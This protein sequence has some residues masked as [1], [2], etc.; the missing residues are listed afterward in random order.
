MKKNIF[1]RL[2]SFAMALVLV[3][4]WLPYLATEVQAAPVSHTYSGVTLQAS[5]AE[6]PSCMGTPNQCYLGTT[7]GWIKITG[8]RTGTV[9]TGSWQG[10]KV[11]YIDYS[12]Y[13][14]CTTCK[15]KR[16]GSGT[17]AAR[18]EA[19]CGRSI[20]TDTVN[21]SGCMLGNGQSINTPGHVISS[22]TGN[23]TS[24]S[25]NCLIH[26]TVSA[27]CSGGT[28]N[29]TQKAVCSTCQTA[30]GSTND[31][32]SWGGWVSNGNNTHTRTCNNNSA[33]K[34]TQNCSGGTAT[35]STPATCK[36]CNQTYGPRQDHTLTYA[37]KSGTTNVLEET[38]QNNCGHIAT[39]TL[40]PDKSEYIFDPEYTVGGATLTFSDNWAGSK[41]YHLSFEDNDD[42]GTATVAATVYA[43]PRN[44]L[45]C[46]YRILPADISQ[47]FA[48]CIPDVYNGNALNAA[49]YYRAK[50][51][52]IGGHKLTEGQDY[53][54]E[55]DQTD[56]TQAGEYNITVTGI[57]NYTGSFTQK[58]TVKP[59]NLKNVSV[60]N[61]IT[62]FDYT[63]KAQK[64]D[65]TASGETVDGSQV[66]FTYRMGESGEYVS[67]PAVTNGGTHTVY[68][69]ASA[70]NHNDVTG[71]FIVT[72][73]PANGDSSVSIAGWS[74]GN[75]ASTPV[76]VSS[77]NGTENVTYQYKIKG[78]D[79]STYIDA[80]PTLPG[81]YTVK[82]SFP[83]T[84]NYKATEATADFTITKR[85]V[86]A[87]VTAQNKTYNGN[88]DAVITA[89]VEDA[90]YGDTL[91]ISGLTGAF[92]DANAGES[93]T[94]TVDS[95]N[96]SVT[97][98][99]ADC[100]VVS[101]PAEVPA[102]IAKA[103][104]PAITFPEVR[105]AITY[106]QS[107][108]EA[109]L[110]FYANDYGT[111]AW[112]A[113]TSVPNAGTAGYALDF[114]PNELALHNY[115]W[116]NA[117]G[118]QWIGSRNA[119]CTCPDVTV[120]KAP[121]TATAP[122]TV[123]SLV[124]NTAPQTLIAAG[125]TNDGT[126]V[127][128][129]EKAGEYTAELPKA[130]AAGTYHVWYKVIGDGN[131]T[132][133]EPTSVEVRIAKA[134][135]AIGTVTAAVV[136]DTL[137]TSAIV[138]T[139]ENTDV[140]GTLTVD[141]E[142][143]LVLGEN[144]IRYTFTP[145]DTANYKVV[146]GEVNVTVADTIAPTG[147]VTIFTKSWAE[148]LNNITFGLF[149]KETQTVSVTAED[150]LSGIDKVEYIESKTALDLD[151]VKAADGWKLMDNGSVSVT[152]EDTKQFVYYIRITDKSG[153]VAYLSSDGA[154]YDTT[155]PVIAGVDNGVTYYSTQNVTV[156]DKNLDTVTLN[157]EPATG[158]VSLAG[159]KEATYTIVATD[160][161]GNS[162][163]VTVKMAPIADIAEPVDGKSEANVTANDKANLQTIV[164]TA[165]ELL[166][167]EDMTAEEKAALEKTKADAEALLEKIEEAQSAPDTENYEKVADVTGDNVQPS[168]KADLEQAKIDLEQALEDY[169]NNYTEEEK[170]I[171]AD[172]IQRIEDAITALE[173]VENVTDIIEA[174][175]ETMKP[176]EDEKT[177]AIEDAK[178][179]YDD[180]SD[181]EK[182]LLDTK[183][184]EKLDAL[185]AAAVA[186]DIIKGDGGKWRKGSD[187]GLSFTANGSLGK[188]LGIQVD[189]KEVDEKHYTA[190]SGSTIITLKESYLKNLS[191]GKHTIT[192]LYEN[193]K[194][195]GTFKIEPKSTS[196]DTGDEMDLLLWSGTM[197]VSLAALSILI[198]GRKRKM[199]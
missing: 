52:G 6:C 54:I 126:I 105:N 163:T 134:D 30:Y 103:A 82:A 49:V 136:N 184:K 95:S 19:V 55:W 25:G 56:L 40:T 1:K 72:V 175:P 195:D 130:T 88:T 41:L 168:D 122:T 43:A 3:A 83:A 188:F 143:T 13:G 87:T 91:V 155:A 178:A 29:C 99:N 32:H 141:A 148:F 146:T 121:S 187:E 147:T 179:A 120:N 199:R 166:K 23:G 33:H 34:D 198:A 61:N 63:G 116:K 160:K 164:D 194:A 149:F 57:N 31:K 37:V 177:T 27:N 167:D 183:V 47:S 190:K 111:F 15:S 102:T 66:T 79:D 132:D 48:L 108:E 109:K 162:T 144:T 110:S 16:T 150:N 114:Y 51:E 59:A 12:F 174:L 173:K 64:L 17:L 53:T 96:A 193:G 112:N 133:S 158:S 80:V 89:T 69:K 75:T 181:H 106:G 67:E 92:T 176:D 85:A 100:Y 90:V 125:S 123:S 98:T 38:C 182:S 119:L 124:Y 36:D 157:G 76:P 156:T 26:G 152:L 180:L 42:V 128:A 140:P 153:N 20:Y 129:L 81:D 62:A 118:A 186:Y 28:A 94:V 65:V 45:T 18:Q 10:E 159:N 172:A 70:P 169:G 7:G 8:L 74:Y 145:N 84:A 9:E 191:N 22:W 189:G 46:Q 139:R 138:L 97:G 11:L 21:V 71:S 165:T 93:K 197:I 185:T 4:G 154:E 171:L 161:A 2:L 78:A 14:H 170:E 77:T 113:P 5:Y 135:P 50:A 60:V 35:C 137:E 107:V 58:F 39:A 192:V 196:P 117:N 115:D 24:H 131:H 44:V 86:T 101:F 151:T 68:W 104:A 73:N 142:Q 127:Y